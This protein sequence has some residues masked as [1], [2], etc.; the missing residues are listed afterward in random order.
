M[1]L[2]LSDLHRYLDN[3]L[4]AHQLPAFLCGIIAGLALSVMLARLVSRLFSSGLARE[5]RRQIERLHEERHNL[6]HRCET[7]EAERQALARELDLTR[8]KVASMQGSMRT[9]REQQTEMTSECETLKSERLDM[10]NRL[11]R[12]KKRL[13]DARHTIQTYSRQLDDI[14]S[15]DGKTWLKPVADTDCPFLPLG[16]RE[17]AIVSLANLK[18]GVGKTTISANLAATFAA[19]GARVLLIDMDH[20]GSLTTLCLNATQKNEV[21]KAERY[22]HRYF[23]TASELRSFLPFVTPVDHAALDHRLFLAAADEPLA[24]LENQLMIRWQTGLAK[25]DVRLRL[26][27]ALHTPGLREHFDLVLIDCPP[28]LTT[29]CINALAASDY[30]LVPVLLEDTSME[31]VPRMIGWVKKFQTTSC[32]HLELLGIVGNKA[33]PRTR[34]V[35]RQQAVWKSL[36]DRCLKAWGKPVRMFDEIIRDHH[37]HQRPFAA[38]DPKYEDAYRNLAQQIRLEIPHARLQPATVSAL[39]GTRAEHARA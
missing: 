33:F 21:R 10:A 36:T 3:L 26:R 18:G 6:Q 8:G 16:T 7:V 2:S 29:G 19:Q 23:D 12:T 17:T 5:L 11:V 34:L 1:N 31:A 37:T 25:D 13:R 35:Q 28:R 38:L 22:I 32:P 30:V 39:A 24:D 20:Q 15:C 4:Q 14:A 9:L 27:R